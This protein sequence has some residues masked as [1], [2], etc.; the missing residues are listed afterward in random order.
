[1]MNR[2]KISKLAIWAAVVASLTLLSTLPLAGDEPTCKVCSSDLCIPVLDE[3]GWVYCNE[4]YRECVALPDWETGGVQ[5]I[6]WTVCRHSN[7]C[8]LA[9]P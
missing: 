1:M 2:S 7:P 9:P 6:C 4:N 3:W 8:L 5:W